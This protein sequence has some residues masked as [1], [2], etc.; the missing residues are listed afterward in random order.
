MKVKKDRWWSRMHGKKEEVR[1][2]YGLKGNREG[3]EE[4]AFDYSPIEM[5]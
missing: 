2:C 3:N 5:V 4:A 1:R